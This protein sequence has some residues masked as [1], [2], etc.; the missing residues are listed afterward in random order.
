MHE[1]QRPAIARLAPVVGELARVLRRG[2]GE[3]PEVLRPAGKRGGRHVAMLISLAV[4][5]PATVSELAARLEISTAHASL[6]VGELAKAGLVDRDHHPDDRRL[7]VVSLSARAK[8]AVAEMRRR[9][10]VPLQRFLRELEPQEADVFIGHL[11]RL[12]E[13]LD[14]EASSRDVS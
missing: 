13:I 3:I 4:A 7:I 10:S 6:V 8:P 5:G 9:T 12:V 11:A 2:R 1:S 14:A